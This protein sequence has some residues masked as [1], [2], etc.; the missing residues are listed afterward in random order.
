MLLE[1]TNYPQSGPYWG[2]IIFTSLAVIAIAIIAIKASKKPIIVAKSKSDSHEKTDF[3][4]E[5]S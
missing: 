2:K 4:T 3:D 5:N 1:Q